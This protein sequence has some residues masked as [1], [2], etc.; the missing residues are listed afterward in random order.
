[1]AEQIHPKE[2]AVSSLFGSA[3]FKRFT[4]SLWTGSF[5]NSKN[6]HQIISNSLNV[7]SK[8]AHSC[9]QL[10]TTTWI[11]EASVHCCFPL[12]SFEKTQAS[13]YWQKKIVWFRFLGGVPFG[14]IRFSK[15]EDFYCSQFSKYSNVCEM[16]WAPSKNLKSF[17]QKET[18]LAMECMTLVVYFSLKYNSRAARMG[19]LRHFSC[20]RYSLCKTLRALTFTLASLLYLLHI[21]SPPSQVHCHVSCQHIHIDEKWMITHAMTSPHNR[22]DSLSRELISWLFSFLWK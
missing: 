19:C 17:L 2:W 15:C 13:L 12:P 21:L 20:I 3:I 1:M 4:K 6:T 18:S 9:S 7:I 11:M 8:I 5:W 16:C 22:R 10:A 14:K